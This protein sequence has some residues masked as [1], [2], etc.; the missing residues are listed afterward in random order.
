MF[1]RRQRKLPVRPVQPD[2]CGHDIVQI[3]TVLAGGRAICQCR[4][5]HRTVERQ[6]RGL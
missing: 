3:V 4:Q 5:C 2:L 6:I 1:L